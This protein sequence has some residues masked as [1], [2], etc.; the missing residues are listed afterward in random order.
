MDTTFTPPAPY[1]TRD[2]LHGT[3][4]RVISEAIGAA[5]LFAHLRPYLSFEGH[6]K[7]VAQ[8]GQ[9]EALS[10]AAYAAAQLPQ[11]C[12]LMATAAQRQTL[13]RL[14]NHPRITLAEKEALLLELPR[15][16][17]ES[18]SAL[19]LSLKLDLNERSGYPVFPEV[20]AHGVTAEVFFV[21]PAQA[22]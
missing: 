20:A 18:A 15:R 14:L 7:A 13:F 5:A 2:P 6:Q 22:A 10:A 17:A 21:E 16:N 19:I 12:E 4:Q 3:L 11:P 1:G 8:L 9:M